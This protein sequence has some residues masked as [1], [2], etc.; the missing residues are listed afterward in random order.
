M[1]IEWQNLFYGVGGG[2]APGSGRLYRSSIERVDIY[3]GA[4]FARI[5]LLCI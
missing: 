5:T 1:M 4:A 3:F 2:L